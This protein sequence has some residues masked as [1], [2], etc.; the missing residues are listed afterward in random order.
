MGGMIKFFSITQKELLQIGEDGVA[1]RPGVYYNF[2]C[3]ENKEIKHNYFI[4]SENLRQNINPRIKSALTKK[5]STR[6]I[7]GR[8]IGEA[9]TK[10]KPLIRNLMSKSRSKSKSSSSS[11]SKRKTH[12]KKK[13]KEVAGEAP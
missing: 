13:D 10:R 6:N 2:V 7:I 3:R 11:G 12:S 4:N 8:L 5:K 9:E 1:K